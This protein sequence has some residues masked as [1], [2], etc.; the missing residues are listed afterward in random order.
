MSHAATSFRREGDRTRWPDARPLPALR[1]RSHAH[2]GLWPGEAG[3]TRTHRRDRPSREGDVMT[4]P[5][6]RR[7]RV[8]SRASSTAIDR[9]LDRALPTARRGGSGRGD[10]DQARYG[11]LTV[12]ASLAT[13]SEAVGS[14]A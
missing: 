6:R 10:G 13:M 12:V 2:A 9:H 5:R 4:R 7:D 8:W 14:P 11:D 1:L 3:E